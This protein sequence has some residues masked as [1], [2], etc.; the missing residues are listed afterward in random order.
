MNKTPLTQHEVFW[1]ASHIHN[2]LQPLIA[3]A[4]QYDPSTRL[5]VEMQFAPASEH[6]LAGTVAASIY[7]GD[8]STGITSL[9][10]T[11]SMRDKAE[12]QPLVAKV[13]AFIDAEQ[14]KIE[15]Q[16][17]L[18]AFYGVEE[19]R[20][21]EEDAA[22]DLQQ[23]RIRERADIERAEHDRDIHEQNVMAGN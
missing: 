10:H 22:W 21:A 15:E 16:H 2:K 14:A 19:A 11:W 17:D 1:L 13:Q 3:A 8:T 9:G 5:K 4:Q 7:Q 23:D 18:E 20:Q 12:L 6:I